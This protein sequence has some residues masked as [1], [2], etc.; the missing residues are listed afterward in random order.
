M[1]CNALRCQQNAN[2]SVCTDF[3]LIYVNFNKT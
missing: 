1:L 2:L 3:H